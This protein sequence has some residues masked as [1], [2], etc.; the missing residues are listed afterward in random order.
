MK[1]I[2]KNSFYIFRILYG[3]FLV[4]ALM[5][6]NK[7]VNVS[8]VPV[9]DPGVPSTE[10]DI[11]KLNGM[12]VQVFYD[13]STDPAFQFGRQHSLMLLNLLGHF[14][15]Y[16]QILGPIEKYKK[17]NLERCRA[18]FYIGTVFGNKLPPEF[19]SDYKTTSRQV[20]WMGYNF[21]QLGPDFEKT[22][23]YRDYVF[24]TLDYTNRTADGKPSYFRD[25]LYKGETF[26]KISVWSPSATPAA[27]TPAPDQTLLAAFEVAK[28]TNKVSDASVVL[29]QTKHSFTNEV[30]PWALK[31][32]NK[33]YISESPFSFMHEADRYFVFA[34]L[35]F[36][37]LN[38]EPKH[39]AKNALLRIEDIHAMV[40]LK[41]L[42]EAITILKRN[43][44]T[45]HIMIVPIFRDPL[46][47]ISREGDTRIEIR[48]EDV[49]QFSA[50][51]ERYKSE[52]SVFIWHG[53]THQYQ[54]IK[55]PFT[56]ASGDDYEFWDSTKTLPIAE[57][58]ASYV[59]DK[60]E[61]GFNSLKKFGIAPKVWVT[62]HYHGSALDN[63]MFGE[64]FSWIIG[65]GVYSDAA[66]TGLKK[67]DPTK[68]LHFDEN[69]EAS[70]QNR[71]DF[72]AGLSVVAPAAQRQ[73][74]QFYPYEIYGNIYGQSVVPE[75]LGN[76]QPFLSNQ[77]VA[78]RNV[79]RILEDA[80][81]N[82]VLRDVWA[83]VFYHPFLLD[84][85]LN[86]ENKD[87]TKPKDLERLV[88]GLK[89]L[90]YKFVNLDNYVASTKIKKGRPKVEIENL[91]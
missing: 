71:R 64:L 20:A 41:Y 84:G 16:Q 15:E 7:S 1:K 87:A 12:C 4:V 48:M 29:A 5:A 52:G 69:T 18:S 77:V 70:A 28:L 22:F 2:N 24:T 38:V 10:L 60:F 80:K 75:N 73:F 14:P 53:I 30:I 31:S 89:A 8:E 61:N 59:L 43:M 23:G 37:I 67:P 13:N 58:S 78:T 56:G 50:L 11:D 6:C 74:G 81:R 90:G 57:D 19:I 26:F 79:A 49:P 32:G 40:D 33:F 76:V 62:P 65:R 47:S 54:N 17:G 21:W 55:N 68:P 82:L 25:V 44:V 86:P 27:P 9:P 3:L 35:L 66:I 36:D 63:V 51:I 45:P 42:D 83:S 85:N 72:F 46:F 88:I 34:D 39:N 91:K